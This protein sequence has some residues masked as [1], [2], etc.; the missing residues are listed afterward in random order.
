MGLKT[1][2]RGLWG[3][4][5]QVCD[6][7]RPDRFAVEAVS[8]LEEVRRRCREKYGDDRDLLYEMVGKEM[9]YYIDSRNNQ[10]GWIAHKHALAR[11]QIYKAVYPEYISDEPPKPVKRLW[12]DLHPY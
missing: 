2:L 5:R 3:S 11:W 12:E 1:W 10:G 4:E 9:Q 8:V 7:E 6:S